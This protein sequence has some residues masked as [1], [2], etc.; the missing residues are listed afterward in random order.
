MGALLARL[1]LAVGL[2]AMLAVLA[3]E[4][5]GL[6]PAKGEVLVTGATTD[7]FVVTCNGRALPLLQNAYMVT[8]PPSLYTGFVGMSIPFAFGLAALISLVPLPWKD[9]G[10]ALRF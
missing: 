6:T 1:A 9:I 4:A 3:L 5:H 2:T 8:H 7:R 10:R